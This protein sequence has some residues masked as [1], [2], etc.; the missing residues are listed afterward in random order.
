M[1]QKATEGLPNDQKYDGDAKDIIKFIERVESK[2]K[3]FGWNSIASNIGPENVNIFNTPGKL[4]A[5]TC[6]LHCD[7]KRMN[8]STVQLSI[9]C[10]F[11]SSLI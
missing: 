11:V 1:N 10:N 9:I 2:G 5:D 6:K 8:G 7:P 3:E 4:T